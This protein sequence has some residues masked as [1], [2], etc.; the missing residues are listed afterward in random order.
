MGWKK[1][2]KKVAGVAGI[3]AAPFTG[4]ASLALAAPMAA[5][6]LKK[7]MSSG[8]AVETGE[9]E[10]IIAQSEENAKKARAR[11]LSTPGGILGEEVEGVQKSSR[12]I[13]G[14]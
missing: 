10:S 4:G 9:A 5:D 13:F 7:S 1:K 3:V 12:K 8:A 11:I 14:N 6:S 2:L